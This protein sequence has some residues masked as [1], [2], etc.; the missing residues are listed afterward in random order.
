MT[1]RFSDMLRN[2]QGGAAEIIRLQGVVR[3]FQGAID[4]ANEKIAE[5]R[6]VEFSPE[7]AVKLADYR[8]DQ[9]RQRVAIN[10]ALG[11]I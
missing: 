7:A 11:S 3:V 1:T 5:I 2:A 9:E 10:S 4:A 6:K 8:E